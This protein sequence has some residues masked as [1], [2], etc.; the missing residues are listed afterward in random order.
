MAGLEMSRVYS[1]LTMDAPFW[2]YSVCDFLAVIG[3]FQE[4]LSGIALNH[5]FLERRMECILDHSHVIQWKA[6]KN[7]AGKVYRNNKNCGGKNI[8]YLAT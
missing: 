7:I 1:L 6:Q 5:N 3:A 8:L 2:I 4:N